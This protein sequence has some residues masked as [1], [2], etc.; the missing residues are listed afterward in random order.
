M[1]TYKSGGPGLFANEIGRAFTDSNERALGNFPWKYFLTWRA[2]WVRH[3][4]A[5]V[6]ED[7]VLLQGIP[8]GSIGIPLG[9]QWEP[10]GSML[11]PIQPGRIRRDLH[12]SHGDPLVPPVGPNVIHRDPGGPH[13]DLS[14]PKWA[15]QGPRC[16]ARG[17]Q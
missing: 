2:L 8:E 3:F 7:P 10:T 13:C 6:P 16:R 9:S 1:P 4:P 15:P 5:G 17:S 14:G 11:A 12:G